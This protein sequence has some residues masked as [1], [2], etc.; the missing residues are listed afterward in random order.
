M[1]FQELGKQ[2]PR[3]VATGAAKRNRIDS[4]VPGIGRNNYQ[5]VLQRSGCRFCV[6][7]TRP[8]NNLELPSD[9]IGTE[10]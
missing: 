10:L 8:N 5:S 3:D 7:K 9:G 4:A 1:I 2:V 6:K